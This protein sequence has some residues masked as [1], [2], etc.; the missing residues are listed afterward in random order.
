MKTIILLFILTLI[1]TPSHGNNQDDHIVS[2]DDLEQIIKDQQQQIDD[3][4]SEIDRQ[5]EEINPYIDSYEEIKNWKITGS[6]WLD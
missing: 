3:N 5:Y 2:N 6:E 1:P 4:N